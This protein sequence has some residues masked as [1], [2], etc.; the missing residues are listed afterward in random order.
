MTHPDLSPLC[1][2]LHLTCNGGAGGLLKHFSKPT[3]TVRFFIQKINLVI[4]IF[5]DVLFNSNV[6]LQSFVAG[7]LSEGSRFILFKSVEA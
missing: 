4:K 7:H 3:L 6:Y 1:D 5:C 2:H